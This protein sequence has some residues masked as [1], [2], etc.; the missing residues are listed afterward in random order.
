MIQKIKHDENVLQ[1]MIEQ[2][3]RKMS[4]K[5]IDPK[6][7]TPGLELTRTYYDALDDFELLLDE[8]ENF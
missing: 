2:R 5:D 6:L 8:L 1:D 3:N 4:Q 7:H